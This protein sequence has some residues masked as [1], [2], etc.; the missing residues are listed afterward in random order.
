MIGIDYFATT[1]QV[2]M[3]STWGLL[4]KY[5]EKFSHKKQKRKH[6]R[7]FFTLFALYYFSHEITIQI[8]Y[9]ELSSNISL[10]YSCMLTSVFC[11]HYFFIMDMRGHFHVSLQIRLV[12]L[13]GTTLLGLAQKCLVIDFF[14]A[15]CTHCSKSYKSVKK[16]LTATYKSF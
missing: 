3:I 14:S 8:E 13:F 15:K 1:G 6:I 16:C 5:E 10:S 9:K 2:I 11:S 12:G 7:F 4:R